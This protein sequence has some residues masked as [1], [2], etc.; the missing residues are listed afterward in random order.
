[1]K[2]AMNPQL[3]PWDPIFSLQEHGEHVLTSVEL[4]VT[5]LCN[6]RCEHCA[7]GDELVMKE[8]AKLPLSFILKKLDEV[9]HLQTISLTGGEPSYNEETVRNYI[10]PIL[11]YAQDRGVRTQINSNVTLDLSRYELMAPYLDVLHISFNYLSADDFHQIGFANATHEVRRSTAVKMYER[12]IDNTRALSQAGLFVS[13]ESMINYRTH[14]RLSDI[15][16]LIVEMGCRR[17]EVHPMYPS[18]FAAHLPKLPLD[19]LRQS[20]SDLLDGRDPDVWM[21]FGT[22][23][24]YS[25][26]SDP[27][28][29]DLIQRLRIEPNVTVR[30][31][32][33]G[34]NRLNVNL[35]TGDVY[36]TDFS[37]LSSLGNVHSD[38]L[39]DV[40]ARWL[41]HPLNLMV[42]CHCPQARCCGPNLL[43]ADA[44]YPEVDFKQ[45]KAVI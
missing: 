7:V 13:A 38:K 40:F 34:R 4:T 17:H 37:D 21:L 32:P 44:Y 26:S 18:S 36:V 41:S 1:M 5:N 10:V 42:N 30:N 23:P 35:F 27:R 3:D 12:M 9:K 43:V 15:H 28:D 22:L 45:R 39:D 31:D 11:K 19:L 14:D 20:I 24:F 2:A 29:R 33:D 16:K 25:C 6:M 8:D